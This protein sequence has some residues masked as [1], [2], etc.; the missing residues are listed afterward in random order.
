MRWWERAE[1]T[2]SLGR[3]AGLGDPDGLSVGRTLGVAET[4][5]EKVLA[6]TDGVVLG[7]FEVREA[8]VAEPVDG[9][10]DLHSIDQHHPA[11]L[12]ML[13]NHLPPCSQAIPMQSKY[14]HV[15]P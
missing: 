4:F 15:Q 3:P 13:G 8:V 12:S 5:V 14:P 2:W 10:D 11:G 1:H 6:L 7:G 9:V